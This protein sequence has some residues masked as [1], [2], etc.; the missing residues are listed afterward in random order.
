MEEA[1]NGVIFSTSIFNLIITRN[2]KS[3]N[4]LIFKLFK[5]N[6]ATWKKGRCHLS[7][8]HG[9]FWHLLLPLITKTG[10]VNRVYYSKPKVSLPTRT[11]IFVS[12]CVA[13]CRAT[14]SDR[15]HTELPISSDVVRHAATRK[16]LGPYSET[17]RCSNLR[18]SKYYR[19]VVFPNLFAAM[20]NIFYLLNFTIFM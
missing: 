20:A 11:M 9:F 8:L 18:H 1:M 15:R 10:T 19:K 7:R 6:C 2:L 13:Q 3:P 4:N 16:Y 17:C 14:R 5:V 12:L